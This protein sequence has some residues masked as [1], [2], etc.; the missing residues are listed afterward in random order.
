VDGRGDKAMATVGV[1][2]G[3]D[4]LAEAVDPLVQYEPMGCALSKKERDALVAWIRSEE[5]S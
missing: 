5:A 1:R 2:D 4:E 3:S